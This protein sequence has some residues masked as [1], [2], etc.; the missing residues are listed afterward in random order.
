MDLLSKYENNALLRSLIQ[1]VPSGIGSAIDTGISIRLTK[2]QNNKLRIFFNELGDGSVPLSEELIEND[3]FIHCFFCTLKAS[4]NSR[5]S[6]K[7]EMFARMLKA[8]VTTDSLLSVDEF[9]EYLNILDELSYREMQI[10][11]TLYKFENQYPLQ[12][13]ENDLQRTHHFWDEFTK[14]LV[15]VI[16]IPIDEVNSILTRLNRT[17]CYETVIGTYCGYTGGKGKLTPTFYRL[18]KIIN[19]SDYYNQY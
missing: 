13:G 6:Q 18:V 12:E 15:D 2:I 19:M 9:E 4:M 17:G 1:L 16:L 10:L 7:I 3:D 11:L 14:E 5:R 8:S